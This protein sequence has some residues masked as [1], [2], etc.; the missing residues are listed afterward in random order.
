MTSIWGR[1]QWMYD[2]APYVPGVR[3]ALHAVV[4]DPDADVALRCTSK[5][6]EMAT[7]RQVVIVDA[8]AHAQV[9]LDEEVVVDTVYLSRLQYTTELAYHMELQLGDLLVLH[10]LD[11]WEDWYAPEVIAWHSQ[12]VAA[13]GLTTVLHTRL[14]GTGRIFGDNVFDNLVS[15]MILARAAGGDDLMYGRELITEERGV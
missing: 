8:T 7:W 6:I 3:G 13:T 15:T 4:G 1:L 11:V 12:Y 2:G 9:A 5:L 10:S 14:L